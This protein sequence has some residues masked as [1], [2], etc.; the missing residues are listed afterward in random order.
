MLM[1][2]LGL[3]VSAFSSKF[4]AFLRTLHWLPGSEDMSHFWV[5]FLELLIL[6]EQWA[7]RRLL[8]EKITRLHVRADRPISFPSVL[9]SE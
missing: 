7:G 8:S 4:T 9:V 1:L 2:L 3:T 5:S 6:F